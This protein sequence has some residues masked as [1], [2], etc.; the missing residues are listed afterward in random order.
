M[1][2][3]IAITNISV[4]GNSIIPYFDKKTS[5]YNLFFDYVQEEIYID[6]TK[7]KTDDYVE[8]IGK[9]KLNVG[10]NN[11]QIKVIKKNE[12]NE[13]YKLVVHNGEIVE[14]KTPYLEV[15]EIENYFLD[16][17]KDAFSYTLNIKDADELNIKFIP[18][19]EESV[20]K[21][22]GNSNLK[23]G[24]NQISVEVKLNDEVVT[25]LINV[26]KLK[27]V[28]EETEIKEVGIFNKTELTKKE[29]I[30][31]IISISSLCLTLIIFIFYLFFIVNKT[32]NSI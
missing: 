27:T 24:N 18:T 17:K 12:T 26:N 10:I 21:V 3:I 22:N 32:K 1:S 8:G 29:K 5:K 2:K 14:E 25:Y 7:E 20:V 11:L 31:V 30:V 15:L 16:F 19:N 4:E 9:I 28:F 6:V 13:T 23:E